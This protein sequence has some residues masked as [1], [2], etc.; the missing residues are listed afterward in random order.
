MDTNF[1]A[2]FS[3]GLG[4]GQLLRPCGITT[5]YMFNIYVADAGFNQV[6]LFSDIG[7]WQTR[8]GQGE[9]GFLK[10][11]IGKL[12]H[13]T[14]VALDKQANL[15]VADIT[16]DCI[17]VYDSQGRFI[18]SIGQKGIGPGEFRRCR[19]VHF[20]AEGYMWVVDAY[21]HRLQKF[22]PDGQFLTSFGS[23]GEK[24]EPGLFNDPSDVAFDQQ[25]DLYVTDSKNNRVQKFDAQGNFLLQWGETG[26][27]HGQFIHPR[28][29]ILDE[30]Q[31]VYVVD[32]GNNRV[33]VFDTQGGFLFAFEG[34]AKGGW[35]LNQ[36]Y[37][38]T[39]NPR[40]EILVTDNY[41]NRVLVFSIQ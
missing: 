20:D 29:I 36:P 37:G 10:K 40:G 18:K 7:K 2:T 26:S 1:Q 8:F 3:R 21:N 25:G 4:F 28:G 14:G 31:R 11:K 5:D 33:Q 30:N 39:I 6:E 24:G 38:I 15:Y 34:P 27:E 13:P 19:A 17:S 41:N 16:L 22:T 9:G 32:T 12:S 35:Q 23:Y